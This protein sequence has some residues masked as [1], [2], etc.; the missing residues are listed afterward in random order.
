ME[1]TN[2]GRAGMADPSISKSCAKISLYI[3]S[4]IGTPSR[5]SFS[6]N[7]AN[8]IPMKLAYQAMIPNDSEVWRI[9]ESG[10]VGALKKALARGKAS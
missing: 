10:D 9:I 4:E 7:Q 2:K 3:R 1:A 8:R 5:V 6:F